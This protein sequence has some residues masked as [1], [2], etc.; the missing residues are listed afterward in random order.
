MQNLALWIFCLNSL[1]SLRY[2]KSSQYDKIRWE[3]FA[4]WNHKQSL[5]SM[6]AVHILMI[7][8]GVGSSCS[9]PFLFERGK[10]NQPIVQLT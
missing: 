2:L 7:D 6:Y 4:F 10:Q 8:F 3:N 1:F 5:D 9:S